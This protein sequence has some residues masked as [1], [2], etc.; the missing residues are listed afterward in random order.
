M[1][2]AS[3]NIKEWRENPCKFVHDVFKVE[4]DRW[5]ADALTRFADPKCKRI[6]MKACAG[7]G[8]TA[9]L[10]WVGWNFLLCYARPGEHPKGVAISKTWD[11]LRDNLWSELAKWRNRSEL[12]QH[13][14]TWQKER[15]FAN[16]HPE[17]WFLSARAYNK[18]ANEE[19]QGR[20]LSG[21]HSQFIFYLIDESG[22]TVPAVLRSAEQGLSSC[23][24]GKIIQAG[25]PT[26]QLGMLY[27][28][29]T[30]ARDQWY[31]IT[32][33]GD[34]DDANR[35]QRIDI[36]WAREQIRLYGRD[37]PWVMAFILGQFPPGGI[38]QL[39]SLEECEAATRRFYRPEEYQTLAKI[40][41]V[42]VARQGPDASVMFGRQGL[43]LT[44]PHVMRNVNSVDG[45]GKVATVWKAWDADA[46]FIDDTGGFGAGWI[47]QLRVMHHQPIGI[48]FSG[49]PLIPH[50]VNRRAEMYWNAAQW[51][52]DG[53]A[54]PDCPELIADLTI[55]TY[56]HRG[57]LIQ[58][59]SKDQ[60]KERLKRSPDWGDAFALTFAQPVMPRF[61]DPMFHT[62][63][64]TMNALDYDPYSRERFG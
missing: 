18:N 27:H 62:H 16:D 4:P 2:K 23:Q 46:C 3:Q 32:I 54:I 49:K 6:A 1:D 33:T 38:N 40:L 51:V 44:K 12:L 56:T 7:P 13:A 35:S 21:L 43:V 30:V 11:N 28:A 20:V 34:P 55:T 22:D 45:A 41:G 24:V 58:I 63:A 19:E 50:Y 10:A 61:K 29:V 14:F 15:I 17:T 36:D 31:I 59:E 52:R 48:H 64:Q 8:K 25:N 53:G 60:I 39:L 37:N 57:D 5:Q 26:S 42:D 47:D 9:L